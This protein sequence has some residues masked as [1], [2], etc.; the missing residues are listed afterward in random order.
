MSREKIL[1]LSN[2][3]AFLL[4]IVA[5]WLAN[6]LPI[7][8]KTTGE[9]S[10][11]YPNLFV[12]AGFTFA[13]WGI[14]YLVLLVFVIY[15]LV[16]A[17]RNKSDATF[18]RDIGWWFVISCLANISWIIAWHYV[19]PGLSLLI[20]LVLL[21]SLIKI[22]LGIRGSA[23]PSK[24]VRLFVL[25]CFSIYLGWIT[26]A[27]IANV[28]TVLVDIGWN[29]LG[30]GASYWAITMVMVASFIAAYFILKQGDFVYSLVII[31]A[32]YGIF[33]KRFNASK[34][35]TGVVAAA[36][37]AMIIITVVLIYQ[38]FSRRLKSS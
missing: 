8:G 27:T 26:V 19:Y 36:L 10:D 7:N 3:V 29:G 13:I 28:T 24:E 17:F 31:W 35:D 2:T 6:A 25:P 14:I 20:M 12:P 16:A 23:A 33:F 38:L 5:N 15:Q 18:I 30:L 1:S 11:M 22:Y 32:L 37:V 9:L 34:V 4:T 21:L